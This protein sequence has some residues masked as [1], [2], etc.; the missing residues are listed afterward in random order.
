MATTLLECGDCGGHFRFREAQSLTC[1]RC[2][3]TIDLGRD[4]EGC[5]YNPQWDV[6]CVVPEWSL[7]VQR[8]IRETTGLVLHTW[9]TGGGCMALA[10]DLPGNRELVI[11]D[12]DAGLPGEHPDDFDLYVA[13]L[14]NEHSEPLDEWEGDCLDDLVDWI[15]EHVDGI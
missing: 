11:T 9:H 3:K 15:R 2:G 10:V 12:G 5:Y 13:V 7:D 14:G 1:N 8:T 6:V 4:T